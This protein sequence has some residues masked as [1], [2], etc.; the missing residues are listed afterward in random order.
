MSDNIEGIKKYR[1]FLAQL[2][3]AADEALE[4]IKD[5][6]HKEGYDKIIEVMNGCDYSHPKGWAY[7][8]ILTL[9]Q[10]AA[11]KDSS[12]LKPAEKGFK[13]AVD[14]YTHIS[15]NNDGLFE[16][17][18]T[19]FDNINKYSDIFRLQVKSDTSA[20]VMNLLDEAKDIPDNGYNSTRQKEQLGDLQKKIDKTK[21]HGRLDITT[22]AL[23]ELAVYEHFLNKVREIDAFDEKSIQAAETIKEKVEL[24]ENFDKEYIIDSVSSSCINIKALIDENISYGKKAAELRLKREKEEA[25]TR[26][27]EEHSEEKAELDRRLDAAKEELKKLDEQFGECE[28]EYAAINKKRDKFVSSFDEERKSLEL[29]RDELN[30]KIN[31]LGLFKSKEKKALSTQLDE[32][33]SKLDEVNKKIADERNAYNESIDK[34]LIP[35]A[36]KKK[37]LADKD[38]ELN[39]EIKLIKEEL[40][41]DRF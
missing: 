37:N 24:I 19:I 34:E 3:P 29:D 32:V 14:F 33:N 27:W 28:K 9:R 10:G 12:A 41:K 25:I 30:S 8:S 35:I 5:G 21:E 1:E 38:N 31:A 2:D 23:S 4:L 40:T 20:A 22:A 16:L 6:K 11:Y 18:N 26:Y 36:E 39:S 7:M 17:G 13:N 15:D